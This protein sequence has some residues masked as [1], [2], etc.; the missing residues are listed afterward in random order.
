M[1]SLD[2]GWT[3]VNSKN[4][5]THNRC[6]LP[7]IKSPVGQWRSRSQWQHRPWRTPV[8]SHNCFVPPRWPGGTR[9]GPFGLGSLFL[10]FKVQTTIYFSWAWFSLNGCWAQ[11]FRAF[12]PFCGE[13]ARSKAAHVRMT[14]GSEAKTRDLNQQPCWIQVTV[15]ATKVTQDNVHWNQS[16][17]MNHNTPDATIVLKERF[18]FFISRETGHKS[19]L[20]KPRAD[21]RMLL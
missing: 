16:I 4:N 21:G 8:P 10:S 19:G 2:V 3:L 9:R 20:K 14:D 5:F 1:A 17:V 7:G 11:K 15:S 6:F 18:M 12:G 13:F